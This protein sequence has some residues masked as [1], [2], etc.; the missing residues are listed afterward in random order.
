MIKKILYSIFLAGILCL[1]ALSVK[2]MYEAD[3]KYII[4][5][6]PSKVQ[7]QDLSLEEKFEV[8]IT[9]IPVTLETSCRVMPDDEY[10]LNVYDF[11]CKK[12]SD[13]KLD[14]NNSLHLDLTPTTKIIR[15]INKIIL[16]IVYMYIYIKLLKTLFYFELF[17]KN[18]FHSHITIICI[19]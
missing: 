8:T 15:Q 2:L 5:I 9:D 12:K 16:R 18:I 1:C 4:E 13:K 10:A 6:D 14:S 3:D 17:F 11:E 19:K 7:M